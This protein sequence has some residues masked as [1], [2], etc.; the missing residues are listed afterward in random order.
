MKK[1]KKR[2]WIRIIAFCMSLVIAACSTAA[3]D[4]V[5]AKT[6]TKLKVHFI[7]VGCGDPF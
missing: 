6:N 4:N 5:E 1:N 7:D 2:I 3:A